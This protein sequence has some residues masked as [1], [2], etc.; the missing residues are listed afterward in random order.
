MLFFQETRIKEI[1]V[2]YAAFV[3]SLSILKGSVDKK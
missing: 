1:R 3:I 2:R